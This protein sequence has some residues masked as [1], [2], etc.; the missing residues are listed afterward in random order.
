MTVTKFDAI[1]RDPALRG[2]LSKSFAYGA[3]TAAYQIEG[4]IDADGKGPNV[5]DDYLRNQD[6][7][8][9]ACDSYRLWREDIELLKRYGC[10]T[11]RFSI[12]W[13]RIRPLGELLLFEQLP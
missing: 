8:N 13:S 10:N 11:Y 4:G 6:N 12:A 1:L 7:G 2:V 3:A 9:L 5:W